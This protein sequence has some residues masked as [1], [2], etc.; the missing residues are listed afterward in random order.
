MKKSNKENE[1][2]AKKFFKMSLS[3]NKLDSSKVRTVVSE[4]KKSYKSAALGVLRSYLSFVQGKIRLQTLAIESSHSLNNQVVQRLK[5]GFEKKTSEKILTQ[6]RQ[7]PNL[8]AGL[9]ITLNDMQWDYSIKG[10]I[11]QMKE[12]LNERYSN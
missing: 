12:H 6:V 8:I 2:I 9:R 1:K 7:N 11:D 3:D 5:N 4:I 10:K